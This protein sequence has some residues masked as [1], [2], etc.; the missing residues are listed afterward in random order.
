MSFVGIFRSWILATVLL[1]AG[2]G[3]RQ[4]YAVREVGL[5]R[6]SWDSTAVDAVFTRSTTLGGAKVIAPDELSVLVLSARYDTLFSGGATT[7]LIDDAALGDHER[8]VVE[9]CGRFDV[10]WICT[11]Q[12]LRSSPK[13]VRIDEEIQYPIDGRFDRGRYAFEARVERQQFAGS[14]WEEIDFT[15]DIGGHL[16]VYVDGA[17]DE[18][19]RIPFT[20]L[21]G[22]FDFSRL[23]NYNNF[24]FNL[25]SQ[26]MDHQEAEVRFLVY[27]GINGE[28]SLLATVDRKISAVTSEHRL[29]NVQG[30]ARQV[31]RGIVHEL[32]SFFGGRRTVASVAA[33]RFDQIEQ[34]Y[35]IDMEVRWRGSF[36]D[37]REYHLA[38]E[39]TVHE[40]G[41][42][43]RFVLTDGNRQGIQ[44]WN[45]RIGGTELRF[46]RLEVERPPERY[47]P[48]RRLSSY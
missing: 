41:A 15:G 24:R 2:C 26:L 28:S 5:E 48:G 44:R 38:G 16:E 3:A 35:I 34:R 1:S 46:E 40:S 27:G 13:R 22:R 10:R 18:R 20:E 25:D 37:D 23:A 6:L 14:G 30:F 36:F 42:S 7:F 39:L 8:V 31:A 32:S 11:Q 17:P 9:C 21:Q 45:Q 43:P 33:W 19:V 29:A 4:E 47:R 12:E